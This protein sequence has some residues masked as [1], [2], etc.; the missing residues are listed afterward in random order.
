[1]AKVKY[2]ILGGGPA[3]LTMGAM[4]LERGETSFLVVEKEDEAGGLCRSVTVDGSP[5]DIGG[6]HFLDVRRPKVDEF[7]FRYLP[8]EEWKEFERD[9]RI[10]M[11]DCYIS[12]PLEANIW[13]LPLDE[14][15]SYLASIARAGCNSGQPMPE[16]FTEWI[17]WKL[18]ERI[19]QDYMLPYNQKMFAQELDELGTY[20]LE[21][22]PDVSFE[23][24]LRSCLLKKP[25]GKQ[26][27]HA[28]FYYPKHYGYGEVWLRIAESLGSH[29][30]CGE[31]VAKL[32]IQNKRVTLHSGEELEGERIITTIPW[33]CL[34]ELK[35]LPSEMQEAVK[36]LRSSSIETRYVPGRLDTK[37]QW[38]YEP[39][40]AKPYHRILVRHNFL[41]GSRGYWLETRVERTGLYSDQEQTFCYE[42]EYA[43]PLNT[44]G[45][46]E[47]MKKLLSFCEREGVYGLG[48]WGEHSHYNSDLVVEKAMELAERL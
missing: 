29:I 35:G 8:R 40:P 28:R 24:T 12:H 17:T 45:K 20:W 19:A 25:Y 18:G 15:V 16:R 6:G 5:F 9:S 47:V 46:P 39:D 11:G 42:N 37:A 21:K 30:R 43:Y 23:D 41:E 32:D 4:L 48:R 44:I 7:L 13:Q 1:M 36:S 26:P 2:L 3:G 14:Q 38:I 33:T 10:A 31:Q 22:L 34:K 27:G